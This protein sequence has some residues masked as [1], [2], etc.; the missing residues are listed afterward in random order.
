MNT[1]LTIRLAEVLEA[2]TG[3]VDQA[4]TAIMEKIRKWLGRNGLPVFYIWG[5]EFSEDTGEHWHS[6]L[7]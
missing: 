3:H 4:I 6:G 5:R 1:L 2:D 7:H